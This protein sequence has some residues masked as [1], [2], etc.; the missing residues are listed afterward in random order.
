MSVPDVNDD[1]QFCHGTAVKGRIHVGL[2]Q[3]CSSSLLW[4]TVR[5]VFNTVH[6][7]VPHRLFC[8]VSDIIDVS[9]RYRFCDQRCTVC[10]TS[11]PP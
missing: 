8:P 3:D 2:R 7:G 1:E 11:V 10:S 9:V 5:R 6:Q 4:S